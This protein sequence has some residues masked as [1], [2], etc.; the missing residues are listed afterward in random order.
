MKRICGANSQDF[1]LFD[2]LAVLTIW[3]FGCLAIWLFGC[4][5]VFRFSASLFLLFSA[6]LF[7]R[8]S[9]SLP[10]AFRPLFQQFLEFLAKLMFITGCI[11]IVC[12]N[13][14]AISIDDECLRNRLKIEKAQHF[15]VLV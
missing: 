13:Y 1:R 7:L 9:V 5:T 2:Y 3:L 15:F 12:I 14:I 8:F 10:S 4:L 6:S 11:A